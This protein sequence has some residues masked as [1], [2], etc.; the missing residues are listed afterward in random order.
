MLKKALKALLSLDDTPRRTAFAFSVGIFVGFSPFLG[1]H[2]VMGLA[3][4]LIFRLNKI[5]VML[6]VYTNSPWVLIPFYTFSTWFGVQITGM[7]GLELPFDITLANVFSWEFLE[8]LAI[9]WPL[10]VP[11]FLGSTVL[12]I[13]MAV[14]AYPLA[15]LIIRRYRRAR[16]SA[17][18]RG[19][20]V[21]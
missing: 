20:P 14:A 8:W 21:S 19:T 17:R 7:E 11:A 5:A 13:F 2:T 9:Q 3:V 18:K 1:L 12:S 15:L 10:L 6:G 16:T 4:A